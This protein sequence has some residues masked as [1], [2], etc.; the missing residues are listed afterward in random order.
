MQTNA[1]RI[2]SCFY[3]ILSKSKY[4]TGQAAKNNT[5]YH[6]Y[7]DKPYSCSFM[8]EISNLSRYNMDLVQLI[9]AFV[10]NKVNLRLVAKKT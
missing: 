1:R 7:H 8:M 10:E 9:L 6:M 5:T 2:Y 4:T 3:K